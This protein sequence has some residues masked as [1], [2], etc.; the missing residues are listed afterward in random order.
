MSVEWDIL[1]LG[2]RVS[3]N[4][5]EQERLQELSH[6]DVDWKQFFNLADFHRTF[7]LVYRQLRKHCSDFLPEQIMESAQSRM[8]RQ[9][10]ENL[11]MVGVLVK[12][13]AALEAH[14]IQAVPFKGPVFAEAVFG[15][16]ALRNYCDLDILIP[17]ADLPRAVEAIRKEG[18]TPLFPL[19]NS[20]LKVLAKTDNEYPLRHRLNGIVIDLQWELTGGYSSHPLHLD[21]LMPNL[22]SF[23]FLGRSVSVFGQEDLLVYLCIHGN[24]HV[25]EQLDQVCCVAETIRTSKNLDWN[26]VWV[27]AGELRVGRM[28]RIGLFLAAS[29]LGAEPPADVMSAIK[30]D[31]QAIIL[32]EERA[33][34][35][36]Q[37]LSGKGKGQVSRRFILYHWKS[38]DSPWQVIRYGCHILFVPTRY[39]WERLPLPA[40]MS[41]LHYIYRPLR[42]ISA[43]IKTFLP[44]REQQKK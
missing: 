31:R 9:G 26:M 12:V 3:L 17:E 8:R 36:A 43:G 24:Q 13:F 6:R 40:W 11:V 44:K 14:G 25:W 34:N 21:T 20:Q 16:L 37:P 15:D 7:A 5:L 32:A 29:L 2:S 33:R 22:T 39:D 30:R 42:L 18:F 27:R 28:V 10:M 4:E 23:D 38:L 1:V 19:E 35:L 41:P